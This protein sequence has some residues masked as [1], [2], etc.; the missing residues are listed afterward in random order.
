MSASELLWH[1]KD[2]HDLELVRYSEERVFHFSIEDW[3]DALKI[4]PKYRALDVTQSLGCATFREKAKK[5]VIIKTRTTPEEAQRIA[6]TQNVTHVYIH[7]PHVMDPEAEKLFDAVMPIVTKTMT[8]LEMNGQKTREILD[9][10]SKYL[11]PVTNLRLLRLAGKYFD[12]TIFKRSP[13]LTHFVGDLTMDSTKLLVEHCP[14]LKY[15]CLDKENLTYV[16]NNCKSLKAVHFSVSHYLAPMNQV[17]LD[18]IKI[19]YRD[20]GDHD[21]DAVN[22][23]LPYLGKVKRLY[24]Q[25]KDRNVDALIKHCP[26]VEELDVHSSDFKAAS[27]KRIVANCPKLRYVYGCT[28]RIKA[29][30][31][32]ER[33]DVARLREEEEDTRP[34]KKA[35]KK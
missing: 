32:G 12:D 30:R 28:K 27:F 8:H 9:K 20:S 24:I 13:N 33:I 3:A 23:A 35:R 11:P 7:V 18:E 16:M 22:D 14:Q 4:F 29:P 31:T 17:T 21:I 26:D 2:C 1:L 15:V 34:K 5:D 25:V 6:S 19:G 10:I